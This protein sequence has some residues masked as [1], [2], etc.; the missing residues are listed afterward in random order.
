MPLDLCAKRVLCIAAGRGSVAGLFSYIPT[1][2]DP[3]EHR[4]RPDP[5]EHRRRPDPRLFPIRNYFWQYFPDY[6][7][8]IL[9]MNI[10]SAIVRPRT[11]PQQITAAGI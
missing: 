7:I 3:I 10:R 2:P 5:I 11:A 8:H 4:R 6:F 1:R 9:K